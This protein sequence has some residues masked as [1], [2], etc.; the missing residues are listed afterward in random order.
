MACTRSA[1]TGVGRRK[2]DIGEARRAGEAMAVKGHVCW[3][4]TGV[5][6]ARL[7]L[8]EAAKE[9]VLIRSGDD[10]RLKVTGEN[11]RLFRFP[12]YYWLS[13]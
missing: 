11:T 10:N 4:Q 5:F 2:H 12:G 7:G 3:Y 13:P 8:T 1:F 9:D 6:A